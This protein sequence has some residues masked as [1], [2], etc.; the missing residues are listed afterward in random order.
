MKNLREEVREYVAL[1]RALG[2]KLHKTEPR[3]NEFV[4]FLETRRADHITTQLAVAWAMESS[5]GHRYSCFERLGIVR[6]FATHLSA[7]DSRTEIPPTRTILR[8]AVALR[9]YIYSQDE[10][11]RLMTAAQNLFSPRKL[12]CHTYYSLIG[13]LATTGLRSGEAVRL[14]TNDVN[15]DQRLLTIRDTKFGK[16]RLVPLHSTTARALVNYRDRRD[17][18]LGKV[19]VPTFFV[20]ERRKPISES[21]FHATFA[22]I[23]RAAGLETTPTGTSPRM[24]DLRHRFAVQTLLSWYRRGEDVERQLPVLS[25]YLGHGHVQDTYWY[26]SS[27]PELLGAACKR[28][29]SRWGW[30]S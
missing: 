5:N 3:L 8:P 23:R 11:I 17:T 14:S 4:A 19:D 28:L 30:T 29:E 18:F 22:T 7:M 9:P 20:S 26:L 24:H 12:R 25:T 13:L 10:I 15:W 2:Y 21:G 16:S 27:T 1:R 6:C